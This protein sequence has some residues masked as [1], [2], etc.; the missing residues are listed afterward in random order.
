MLVVNALTLSRLVAGLATVFV[1]LHVDSAVWLGALFAYMLVSDNLDGA[2]ARH[3]TVATVAG[4]AFDYAVDRFN[5][6]LQV[7][8]LTSA[9][10]PVWTFI[11]F[12]LRDL[13]YIFV[14]TYVGTD[15]VAGTKAVGFIGTGATYLY[16]LWLAAGLPV[17][18]ELNVALI[19]AYLL[20]CAN[21]GRRIHSQ[22]QAIAER[23]RSDFD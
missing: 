3:W 6:Y 20:S 14:Q 4:S 1:F 19:A 11:P 15:R 22:R 10:V 2:L 7:G 12:F 9:G 8:L 23:I 16:V 18:A 17:K 5:T 13:A 21:L